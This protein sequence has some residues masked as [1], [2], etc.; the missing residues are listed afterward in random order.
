MGMGGVRK[1]GKERGGR[2]REMENEVGFFS[3]EEY[4]EQKEKREADSL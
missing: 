3:F 4:S 2:E 1:R